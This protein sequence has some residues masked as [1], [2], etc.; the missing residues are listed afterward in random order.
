MYR[1][2]SGKAANEEQEERV[3]NTLKNITSTTSNQHPEHVLL[4]NL[5]RVQVREEI[6]LSEL[7]KQQHEVR[8][9]CQSLQKKCNTTI[10]FWVNDKYA[11][12]WQAHLELVADYINED[13]WWRETDDGIMFLD[14]GK[15]ENYEYKPHHFRSWNIKSELHYLKCCCEKCLIKPQN[16][17]AKEI[18]IE[19]S[20]GQICNMKLNTIFFSNILS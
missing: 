2:T 6:N 18:K 8:K 16:I 1:I 15:N 5:I 7:T 10:P 14:Y 19:N 13:G 20:D 11:G 9:L 4:N 17:P 3:F 12:E